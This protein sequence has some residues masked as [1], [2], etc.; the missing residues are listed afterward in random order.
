MGKLGEV[1]SNTDMESTTGRV[2][3]N[4]EIEVNINRLGSIINSIDMELNM[5]KLDNT[6]KIAK[7]K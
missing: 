2:N 1:N 7:K 3:N 5:G 6:N 4:M